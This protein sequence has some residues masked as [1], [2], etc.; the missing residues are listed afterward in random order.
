MRKGI[1]V[2]VSLLSAL[3]AGCQQPSRTP[4]KQSAAA[5]KTVNKHSAIKSN[6]SAKKQSSK[7]A[8]SEL[9]DEQKQQQLA[10]FMT[11]WGTTMKQDYDSYRPG[12]N[13]DFYGLK[14]PAELTKGNL[15]ANN[16]D[17]SFEWSKTGKGHADYEVVGI[18]SDVAHADSVSAHL[19]F[20]T[21]HQGQPVVLITEQNQGNSENKV[22]FKTTANTDLSGGF[23]R[24]VEGKTSTSKSATTTADSKSTA[25]SQSDKQ[26]GKPEL[27]TIDP[28]MRGTWYAVN[29]DGKLSTLTFYAHSETSKFAGEPSNKLTWYLP[30]GSDP[31]D[32]DNVHPHRWKVTPNTINKYG[33]TLVNVHGWNQTAGAG[34]YYGAKQT[35]IDGKST[36]VLLSCGG[37]GAWVDTVYYPSQAMAEQQTDTRIAGVDYGD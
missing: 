17:A 34:A 23:S 20:F 8:V 37:A 27:Y 33:A 10:T 36:K 16:E 11:S 13:T 5:T 4:K 9:W 22:Y 15:V 18:Y 7:K 28:A 26:D 35:K 19:Y 1:I 14:Y 12:H 6:H 21:I 31:M 25:S 2:A 32:P 29:G 3:L 30:D 24:I